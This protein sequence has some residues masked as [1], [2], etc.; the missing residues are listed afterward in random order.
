MIEI[1]E[2]ELEDRAKFFCKTLF[3]MELKIPITFFEGS[4][5]FADVFN[6]N[7]CGAFCVDNDDGSITDGCYIMINQSQIESIYRL[8]NTIIHELIHYYLWYIGYGYGDTEPDFLKKA[9]ELGISNN[10]EFRYD[11]RDEYGRGTKNC[12]YEKL[13]RYEQMYQNRKLS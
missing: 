3:G 7:V 13:E 12:D 5:D 8:D 4:N 10:Y 2:T 6:N 9:K 1:L 11:I